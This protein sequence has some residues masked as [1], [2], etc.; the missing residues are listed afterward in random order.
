MTETALRAS[1][2]ARLQRWRDDVDV[3]A[4]RAEL[5]PPRRREHLAE[6]DRSAQQAAPAVLALLAWALAPVW[7]AHPTLQ[8]L[9]VRCGEDE[10]GRRGG[11]LIAS[12]PGQGQAT[13]AAR[14][15]LRGVGIGPHELFCA[16]RPLSRTG[17]FD[18]RLD[19]AGLHL[20]ERYDDG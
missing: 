9:I 4:R 12:R 16:L 5:D 13:H 7:A 2:R 8:A 20:H 10:I 18:V 15:A 3:F 1:A 14:L 6:L 19:R 11:H 17:K